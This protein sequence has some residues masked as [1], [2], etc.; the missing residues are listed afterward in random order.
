MLLQPKL[1]RKQ[2][3]QKNLQKLLRAVQAQP[4]ALV[5]RLEVIGVGNRR[6]KM[7]F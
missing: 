1:L 7:K 6:P 3:L 5:S 2:A 4:V